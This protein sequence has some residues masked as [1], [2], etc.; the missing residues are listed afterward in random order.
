M[1][2]VRLPQAAHPCVSCKDLFRKT[3]LHV[4]DMSAHIRQGLSNM[5]DTPTIP[6]RVAC[7]SL[8]ETT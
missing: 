1:V 8:S 4:P 7:S 3:P 5:F 6:K 2:L